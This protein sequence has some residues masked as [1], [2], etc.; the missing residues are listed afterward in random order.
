MRD[1]S[2]FEYG[3]LLAVRVFDFHRLPDG[4]QLFLDLAKF[5][6]FQTFE[7]RQIPK[8]LFYLSSV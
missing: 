5:V 1:C 4:Q 3:Q 6:P 7:D 2:L 8:D